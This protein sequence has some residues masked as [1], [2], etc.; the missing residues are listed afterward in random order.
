MARS[1]CQRGSTRACCPAP[2]GSQCRRGRRA[3]RSWARW[4]SIPRCAFR[5]SPHAR[6]ASRARD[7]DMVATPRIAWLTHEALERLLD[8]LTR[9]GELIAP[10]EIEGD[11]WF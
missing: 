10:V 7:A 1:R 3:V 5:Y 8:E 11:V 6:C 4:R 9:A 2:P